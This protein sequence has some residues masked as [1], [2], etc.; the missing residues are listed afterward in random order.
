MCTFDPVYAKSSMVPNLSKEQRLG[1]VSRE[2]EM[3]LDML[4]GAEDCKWIYQSL[5][6]L[7]TMY[8]EVSGNWP[9]QREEMSTWLEELHKLDPLRTGRWV[10]MRSKLGL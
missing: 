8:N 1:Y 7:C 4:D 6:Q 10:D 9:P 5:L 2:I 3:L